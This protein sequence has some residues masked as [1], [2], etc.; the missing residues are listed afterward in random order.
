MVPFEA[1]LPP[2]PGAAAADGGGGVVL[3]KPRLRGQPNGSNNASSP[4]WSSQNP[5]AP[6]H[7]G[8]AVFALPGNHGEGC[9]FFF[10]EGEKREKR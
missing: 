5:S 4:S 7:A 1:A 9:C 6:P 2:P 8:P 10:S 3:A